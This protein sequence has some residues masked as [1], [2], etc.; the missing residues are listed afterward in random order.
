MSDSIEDSEHLWAF[1]EQL[2]LEE[3]IVRLKE[4]VIYFKNKAGRGIE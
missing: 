4:L 1:I 2:P 3:Q